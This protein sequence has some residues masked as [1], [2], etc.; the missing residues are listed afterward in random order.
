MQARSLW[1]G[2][3]SSGDSRRTNT[4]P[5]RIAS[6]RWAIQRTCS[7]NRSRS[8]SAWVKPLMAHIINVAQVTS[9][10]FTF[11]PPVNF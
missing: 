1:P 2:R 3:R 6:T 4:K 11:N 8:S 5:S 10:A 7:P 9:N